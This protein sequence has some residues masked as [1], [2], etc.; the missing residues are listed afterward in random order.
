MRQ[1]K[2]GADSS[3][4][5]LAKEVYLSIFVLFY[6]LSRWTADM[7]AYSAVACLSIVELLLAASFGMLV[8]IISGYRH[9]WNRWVVGAFCLGLFLVNSH[10]LVNRGNGIAFEREFS[11]YPRGKRMALLLAAGGIAVASGVALFLSGER[12]HKMLGMIVSRDVV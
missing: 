12:Y 5:R 2:I 8:Q 11:R 10:F 7:K 6:R 3:S 1:R 9:G 4:L